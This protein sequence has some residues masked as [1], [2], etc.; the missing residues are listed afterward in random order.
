MRQI[1]SCPMLAFAFYSKHPL[2]KSARWGKK[3]TVT[4]AKT[5]GTPP[6]FAVLKEKP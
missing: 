1:D 2:A 6:R 3:A 4:L 5:F